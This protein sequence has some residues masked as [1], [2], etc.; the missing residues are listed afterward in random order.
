MLDERLF[1]KKCA[2][3]A[4]GEHP[5]VLRRRQPPVERHEHRSEPRACEEQHERQRMVESQK[6]DRIASSNTQLRENRR[7]ALYALGEVRVAE[8]V[9]G[10]AN[11]RPVRRKRRVPFNPVRKVHRWRG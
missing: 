6:G 11:R 3:G 8:V 1:D 5:C 2:R 10:E 9:T 7:S 4:I